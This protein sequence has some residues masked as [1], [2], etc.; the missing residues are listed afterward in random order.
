MGNKILFLNGIFGEMSISEPLGIC[1]L[2]SVVRKKG[3][4]EISIYDPC[5]EGDSIEKAVQYVLACQPDILAISVIGTDPSDVH[6]FIQQF[7]TKNKNSIIVIGGHGPS[8]CPERFINDDVTGIFVGEGE[9]TWPLFLQAINDGENIHSVSGF[10]YKNNDGVLMINDP[11]KKIENLDEL[12]FMARDTLPLLIKKYGK[13]VSAQ[14]LSSRS[15]Y[16]NCS[17]CSIKAFS[18]LQEGKVYRERSVDSI[19]EEIK[20]LYYEFGIRKIKFADDNFI[21]P[22][23]VHAE[24]K[25]DRFYG[26]IIDNN[27]TD[28]HFHIQC[29]PDNI[30]IDLLQKLMHIGMNSLFIG[31]E[32]INQEDLDVYHR[33]GNPEKTYWLMDE[34]NKIGISC[35][36]NSKIRMK[37]GYIT[38]N[39]YSTRETLSKSVDFLRRYQ[40]TPKKLLNIIKPYYKTPIYDILNENHLLLSDNTIRFIDPD[41]GVLYSTIKEIMGSVLAFRERIRLP[42]KMHFKLNIGSYHSEL[43]DF[44]KAIDNM[45]FDVFEELLNADISEF[46]LIKQK[47]YEKISAMKSDANILKILDCVESELGID[48]NSSKIV[49]NIS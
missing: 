43:D 14:M 26:K 25:I 9:V 21:P 44:R 7:R 11:P 19:I 46:S 20:Y 45:C 28:I 39:P 13:N 2:A 17:Y 49:H 33:V 32:S 3:F 5:V 24:Q 36:I 8:L 18:K 35:N 10:A 40:I 47:Y 1:V 30:K 15:C 48:R 31:V 12:P 29:R 6:K 4:Q 37:L 27:M 34:L 22:N 41:I 16:M 38:F 23:P 42:V